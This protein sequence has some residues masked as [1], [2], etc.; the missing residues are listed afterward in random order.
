[1]IEDGRIANVEELLSES[2]EEYDPKD[3]VTTSDSDQADVKQD[4]H[5]EERSKCI[6]CESSF[7]IWVV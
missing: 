4:S 1:V 3:D 7:F 5:Q 2:K 6:K